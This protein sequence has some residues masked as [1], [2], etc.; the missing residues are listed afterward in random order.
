MLTAAAFIIM[1]NVFN[2]NRVQNKLQHTHKIP[3]FILSFS[4]STSIYCLYAMFQV[5]LGARDTIII[6]KRP[7]SYSYG[8]YI[9]VRE[10]SH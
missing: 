10:E 6:Q 7:G 8:I 9:L 2:I 1:K 4:L 3:S 5:L